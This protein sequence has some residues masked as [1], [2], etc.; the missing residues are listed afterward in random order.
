M[1]IVNKTERLD[2]RWRFWVGYILSLLIVS[3]T[4]F[5]TLGA[6]KQ[7]EKS[8]LTDLDILRNRDEFWTK[9]ALLAIDLDELKDLSQILNPSSENSGKIIKLKSKIKEQIISL[10]GE[11]LNTPSLEYPDKVL[12]GFVN[13]SQLME[14]MLEQVR[15]MKEE[16]IQKERDDC[17]N[18]IKE[19]KAD[20]KQEMSDLRAQ[21]YDN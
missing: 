6:S 16:T 18:K 9:M 1:S 8:E 10:Q 2:S 20:H 12:R 5:F 3:L 15:T 14:S 4:V 19:L 7:E 17:A 11:F 13:Y 21:L